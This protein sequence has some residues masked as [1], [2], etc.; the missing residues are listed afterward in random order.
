METLEEAPEYRISAVFKSY[1]VVWKRHKTGKCC[2]YSDP[3]PYYIVRFKLLRGSE[4]LQYVDSFH[5]T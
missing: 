4:G 5:T 2:A 3:F 1:Y